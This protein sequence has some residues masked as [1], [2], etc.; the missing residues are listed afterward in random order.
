MR[1][2]PTED[3][4]YFPICGFGGIT[5]EMGVDG[6]DG[7]ADLPLKADGI[8]IL[9]FFQPVQPFLMEQTGKENRRFINFF[10]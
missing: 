4:L 9:T 6:V 3:T 8:G 1:D 5:A 2:I 7:A 10:H